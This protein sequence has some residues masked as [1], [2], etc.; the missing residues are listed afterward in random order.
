MAELQLASDSALNTSHDIWL[1]IFTST[2]SWAFS[3][4]YSLFFWN[5]CSCPHVSRIRFNFF[6]LSLIESVIVEKTWHIWVIWI[7]WV[8]A[9]VVWHNHWSSSTIWYVLLHIINSASHQIRNKKKSTTLYSKNYNHRSNEVPS[10]AFCV[11]VLRKHLIQI[12][13]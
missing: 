2:F 4:S 5:C 13:E 3:L 6:L 10:V 1:L 8:F 12:H 11:D 9:A 7:E